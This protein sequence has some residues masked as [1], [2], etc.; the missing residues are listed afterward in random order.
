M[1]S[2]TVTLRECKVTKSVAGQRTAEDVLAG[3]SQRPISAS[4]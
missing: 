3:R 2:F 4:T 1:A